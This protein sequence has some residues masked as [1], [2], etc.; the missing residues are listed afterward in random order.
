MW[1]MHLLRELETTV[2]YKQSGEGWSDFEKKLQRIPGDS[3]R[4]WRKLDEI[5]DGKLIRCRERLDERLAEQIDTDRN[6]KHA[7]RLIK[8]L[9]RHQNNLLTFL[10]KDDVPFD[11]RHAET[12]I[13]PAVILRNIRNGNRSEHGSN[14]QVTVMM[15]FCTLKLR[16]IDPSGTMITATQDYLKIGKLPPLRSAPPQ[17]AEV[18]YHFSFIGMDF[19]GVFEGRLILVSLRT[20]DFL[21]GRHMRRLTISR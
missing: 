16:G 12:S 14:C 7:D 10:Y 13:R 19:P 8:R 4:P 21:L 17:R 11:N 3:T 15:I 5:D 9:R 1:L 20:A 18:L 6:D 2:K